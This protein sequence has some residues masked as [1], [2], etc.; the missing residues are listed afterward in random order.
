M[1]AGL[2]QVFAILLI[3]LF[4]VIGLIILYFIVK[5]AVRTGVTEAMREVFKEFKS[6]KAEEKGE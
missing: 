3:P 5:H 2:V 6:P 4:G 1:I